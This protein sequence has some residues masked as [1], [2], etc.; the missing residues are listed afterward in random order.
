MHN[1]L[2]IPNPFL[3]STDYRCNSFVKHIQSGIRFP[4]MITSPK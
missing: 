3:A 4:S 1:T 2:F